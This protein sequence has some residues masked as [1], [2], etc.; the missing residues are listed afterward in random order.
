MNI[1][2]FPKMDKGK[3]KA[4]YSGYSYNYMRRIVRLM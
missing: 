4:C 1:A 2:D 3:T